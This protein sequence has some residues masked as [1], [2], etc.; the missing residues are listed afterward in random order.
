M[1]LSV[2]CGGDV[3]GGCVRCRRNSVL[4]IT[5][6]GGL[7]GGMAALLRMLTTSLLDEHKEQCMLLVSGRVCLA[8]MYCSRLMTTAV[9]L[10]AWGDF[11]FSELSHG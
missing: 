9:T 3:S 4:A 6:D 8:H 10:T 5:L 11:L 2:K 7:K 1:A